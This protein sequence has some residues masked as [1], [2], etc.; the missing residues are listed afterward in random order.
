MT[1]QNR[2]APTPF[3]SQTGEGKL[4]LD[5]DSKKN[6]ETHHIVD[7]LPDRQAETAAAWMRQRPDIT[8]VSRDRG[9]EYA[10]AAADGAPQA[11]DV[12]DRFHIRKNLIEALQLL[13]GRSLEE[14]KA[15]NQTPEQE[16]DEP[17]KPVI[18]MEAWRRA[19]PAHVQKAR[20]AR[21]SGRYARYQ[22][23]VELH[24][25]GMKLKARLL[26]TS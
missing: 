25:Q 18:M 26:D 16:Q 5:K 14:I 2:Q 22:Q 15:A 9:G 13:L 23:V 21:R 17:N 7:L 19:E 8:V 1:V 12:A 24:E 6:L 4:P 20:L 11:T 10:K 3:R